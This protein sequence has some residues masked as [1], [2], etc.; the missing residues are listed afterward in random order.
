MH[1][2]ESS[3]FPSNWVFEYHDGIITLNIY[4]DDLTC[5]PKSLHTAFWAE[6]RKRV[7][8]DPE[9]FVNPKESILGQLHCISPQGDRTVLTMNM[10]EYA[11]QVVEAYFDLTGISPDELRKVAT[12]SL[13]ESAMTDEDVAT[14]GQLHESASKVLMKALWLARL[15]R[16]DIAFAVGKL[17][18]RVTKW[19][20][21]ED[22][23]IFRLVSYIH[24]TKDVCVH[25]TVTG[26]A[27]AEL[28]A[29]T[30]ADFSSCPHA[31]KSASGIV[32]QIATGS[33][34][35]PALWQ[36]Q[37]LSSGARSMPE[38]ECIAMASAMYGDVINLQTFLQELL[39]TTVLVK[40]FQ[41]NEAVV[42]I[43]QAGFSAKLCHLSRVHKGNIASM[44]EILEDPIRPSRPSLMA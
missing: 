17:A 22:R 15:C 32:V 33:G 12:L 5:G 44:T 28:H 3:E 2:K 38:A 31:A 16:A 19:T 21:W 6:L 40:F 14:R 43:L 25:A 7:K 35:F 11:A 42:K 13:P 8:L 30:D 39:R 27:P 18:T 4:V 10:V 26:K 41:D 23:Q 37:K 20:A 9:A 36:S 29:F 34:R 24:S 1:G